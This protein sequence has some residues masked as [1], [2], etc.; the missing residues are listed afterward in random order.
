M[1][2]RLVDALDAPH[3]IAGISYSLRETITERG[4]TVQELTECDPGRF[5]LSYVITEGAPEIANVARAHTRCEDWSRAE[6][7]DRTS[8]CPAVGMC[9]TRCLGGLG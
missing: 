7:V 3:R 2:S 1:V 5:V 8:A 9:H 6:G 4:R